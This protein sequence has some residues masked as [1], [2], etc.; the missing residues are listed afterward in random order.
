MQEGERFKNTFKLSPRWFRR[1]KSAYKR[2]YDFH[3]NRDEGQDLELMYEKDGEH[4]LTYNFKT[5]E[6]F[7][8]FTLSKLTS[9]AEGAPAGGVSAPMATL[10]NTPGMG[11]ATPASMAAMTG[12]QQTNP[13]AR[14]S[15]D[16]WTSDSSVNTQTKALDED[17][18]NP[19]D[20]VGMSM[21]KKMG[22][23]TP[24]KKG[25]EKGNQNSVKQVVGEHTIVPLEQFMNINE[26]DTDNEFYRKKVFAFLD[27][28]WQEDAEIA[29]ISLLDEYRH[30]YAK[31]SIATIKNY[32]SRVY[33]ANGSK[34]LPHVS[35]NFLNQIDDLIENREDIT[36]EK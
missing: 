26:N 18:I 6:C 1:F 14:G 21:A 27:A 9:I 33:N 10:G 11:N 19:T 3:H 35:D 28:P 24:F 29:F 30:L 20:K 25:K 31:S 4:M 2:R 12:A 32:L 7:T 23:K 13:A 34:I 5:G 16:K 17:N 22:V 15:G 36:Q 8:D